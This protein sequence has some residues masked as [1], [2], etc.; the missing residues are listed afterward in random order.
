MTYTISINVENN[1]I[2]SVKIGLPHGNKVILSK[3]SNIS[4][5][6][7]S[8]NQKNATINF[9][10]TYNP[11]STVNFSFAM[12]DSNVY[13]Y[14]SKKDLV[15]YRITLGSIKGFEVNNITAKWNKSNVFFQ[16]RGS[17]QGGY[18]VLTQKYSIIR[19]LQVVTQYK[20]TNFNLVD[21]GQKQNTVSDYII[22]YGLFVI[23]AIIILLELFVNDSYKK[24][25]GFS[26]SY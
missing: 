18:Y 24:N 17:E 1:A 15:K 21:G 22:R 13:E 19:S 2:N 10:N 5:I 25:R 26:L 7:L 14:N 6:E 23:A 9:N 20:G 8:D 16:G 4:S 3:D 12:R 11:G